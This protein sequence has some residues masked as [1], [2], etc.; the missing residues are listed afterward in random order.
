MEKGD[1]IA[2]EFFVQDSRFKQLGAG[3]FNFAF[4]VDEQQSSAASQTGST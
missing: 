4:G 3:N 2:L 1:F